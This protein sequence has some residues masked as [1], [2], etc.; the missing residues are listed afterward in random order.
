[1]QTTDE[2]THVMTMNAFMMDGDEILDAKRIGWPGCDKGA[3]VPDKMQVASTT[4]V[5]D[6]RNGAP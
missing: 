2:R 3:S 4:M 6:P 5:R 1:M